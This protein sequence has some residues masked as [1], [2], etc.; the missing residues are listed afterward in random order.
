MFEVV[1]GSSGCCKVLGSVL[2]S[3]DCV[4]MTGFQ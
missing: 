4:L 3:S 2:C 1:V